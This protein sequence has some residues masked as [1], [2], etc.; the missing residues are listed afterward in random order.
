MIIDGRR[1]FDSTAIETEVCIIGA[2]V[3]GIA[4]A[5]E[6]D[7]AGIACVLL[8]SGG[9]SRDEATADLYRGDS[10]GL[11]YDFADGK[12]SRYL[13]GAATAGAGSVV[14]GTS[15]PS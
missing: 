7:R 11:P 5:L 12:R 3:A 13:G 6:L 4:I 15:R 8:E 1:A 10:D 14:P 9:E 2:G